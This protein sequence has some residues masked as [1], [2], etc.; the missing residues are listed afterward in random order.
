[1]SDD[2]TQL[3]D[4]TALR[5]AIDALDLDLARLLARR[6]R[7]IDRA[8]EIKAGAGLPA[9]IDERVEEVAEKARRN[10][11]ATG[12]DPDLAEALWRLMMEHFIAQEARQLGEADDG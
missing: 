8:A 10:A 9:R 4:M 5:A 2:L 6:S 11:A 1:M 3:R 7:L 12:Y